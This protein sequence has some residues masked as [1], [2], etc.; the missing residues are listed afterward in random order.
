MIVILANPISYAPF[1]GDWSRYISSKRASDRTMILATFGG[2]MVGL[3]IAPLFGAFMAVCFKDPAGDFISGIVNTAPAWYSVVVLLL[4]GY[5]ALANTSTG[6]Y[7][8]G[9]DTSSLIPR[10]KRVPATLVLGGFAVACVYVGTFVVDALSS[11]QAF[12]T[13]LTVVTVPWMLIL[14]IGH[15]WRRGHY[16]LGDLQVFNRGMRGGVYWYS[17]GLN[18]RA[19]GAWTAAAVIGLLFSNVPPLWVAPFA[20]VAGGVD[21]SLISAGVLGAVFYVAAMLL[22]PEPDYLYGPEGPRIGRTRPGRVPAV[23]PIRHAELTHPHPH[24]PEVVVAEGEV[25]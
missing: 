19:V 22:F 6:M 21:L 16:D 14:A 10:L 3:T 20:D 15:W 23:V 24:P 12:V 7:G 17:G 11:I 5:G 13:V 9:L 1:I 18:F 25:V 2:S 4:G 8:P